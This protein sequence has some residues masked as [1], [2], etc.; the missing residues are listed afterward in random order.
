MT[1]N[2]EKITLEKNLQDQEQL[3]ADYEKDREL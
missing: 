1:E 2:Q 3:K